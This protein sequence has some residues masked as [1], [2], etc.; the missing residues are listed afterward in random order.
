MGV[1]FLHG[2]IPELF[3][4]RTVSPRSPTTI[5][6]DWSP[7]SLRWKSDHPSFADSVVPVRASIKARSK[8]S[9]G[10]HFTKMIS[11]YIVEIHQHVDGLGVKDEVDKYINANDREGLVKLI[12]GRVNTGVQQDVSSLMYSIVSR[13][14]YINTFCGAIGTKAY[15]RLDFFL[16]GAGNQA[17][18]ENFIHQDLDSVRYEELQILLDR[19]GD[20][21]VVCDLLSPL[22]QNTR[23]QLDS[24]VDLPGIQT[25]IDDLCNTTLGAGHYTEIQNE[26]KKT[27]EGGILHD[28]LM[29]S[30]STVY[31]Q[32]LSL[33][34]GNQQVV[35]KFLRE[36]LAS[37]TF[38]KLHS[39]LKK[40]ADSLRFLF[41]QAKSA[42][43]Y[44]MRRH[45]MYPDYEDPC[46]RLQLTV[47]RKKL[48][49]DEWTKP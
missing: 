6:E 2:S 3:D 41:V 22:D 43:I 35:E 28:K 12:Q 7:P 31:Q 14:N 13:R 46:Y 27:G 11:N 18:L 45:Y 33:V 23:N 10:W 8:L 49:G 24:L 26:I 1:K 9:L 17:A 4:A 39:T 20:T 19:A 47:L 44:A 48:Y 36:K 42:S 37:D 34:N 38:D 29:Y 15:V 25:A 30:N 40:T 16:N 21:V 5:S 32:Y